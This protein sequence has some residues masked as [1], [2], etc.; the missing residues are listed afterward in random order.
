MRVFWRMAGLVVGLPSPKG[1]EKAPATLCWG[2]PCQAH[3]KDG[4]DTWGQF[5]I[6]RFGGPEDDLD[7]I[8]M[9]VTKQGGGTQ[10]LVAKVAAPVC[11]PPPGTVPGCTERYRLIG[12][13]AC[14][15]NQAPCPA[16]SKVSAP[17]QNLDQINTLTNGGCITLSD[18]QQVCSG[19]RKDFW[20]YYDVCCPDNGQFGPP[21]SIIN[22]VTS[23]TFYDTTV[24]PQSC[25][26]DFPRPQAGFTEKIPAASFPC[27]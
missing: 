27:L 8:T 24:G 11:N 16:T 21:G 19:K 10:T 18:G 17:I 26:T 20:I 15:L 22:T 25:A 1:T 14:P 7:F 2:G 4:P 23:Y 13:V 12:A 6:D 3:G 5:K 9:L